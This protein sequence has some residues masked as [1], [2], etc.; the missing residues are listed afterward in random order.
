MLITSIII[1]LITLGIAFLID[2]LCNKNN[3]TQPTFQNKPNPFDID[4]DRYE[5]NTQNEY[6]TIKQNQ[7]AEIEFKKNRTTAIIGFAF[8]YA[9]NFVFSLIFQLIFHNVALKELGLTNEQLSIDPEAFKTY[10]IVMTAYLN[11]VTMAVIFIGFIFIF[12]NILKKDFI[13]FKSTPG[14]YFGLFGIGF[15]LM[16]VANIIVSFIIMFF[17]G[18]DIVSS[19]QNLLNEVF[20]FNNTTKILLAIFTVIF[21]PVIEELLFRKSIFNFFKKNTFVPIIVSAVIFAFIHV[22]GPMLSTFLEMFGGTATFKDVL[23]EFAYI[24][25]YLPPAFVLAMV[26]SE[27]KNNIYPCILIH[28]AQ[29]LLSV[30]GM[31]LQ[32]N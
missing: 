23:I 28:I 29:N 32:Q 7:E 25:I 26:Y 24:G 16:Y 3:I 10:E 18:D 31:F 14:K 4:K 5:E 19:N 30:I 21:A 27:G 9:L 8:Y 6:E 17:F 2:H 12:K 15:V 22:S 11:F 1:I 20:E 13:E